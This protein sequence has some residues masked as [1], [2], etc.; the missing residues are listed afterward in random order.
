MAELQSQS[1]IFRKMLII[2]TDR[3]TVTIQYMAELQSQSKIIRMMLIICTDRSNYQ[4]HGR[5]ISPVKNN[6]NDAD[7]I[8]R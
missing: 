5:T 3:G 8:Y 2:Y 4:T 7:Y 1:K 6:Q